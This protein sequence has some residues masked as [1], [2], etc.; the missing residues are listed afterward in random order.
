MNSDQI[1]TPYWLSDIEEDEKTKICEYMEKNKIRLIKS[2]LTNHS[3]DSVI[4]LPSINNSLSYEDEG[5][6]VIA[7]DISNWKKKLGRIH[8][9]TEIY[10]VTDIVSLHK[11]YKYD[12]K[13]WS[14]KGHYYLFPYKDYIGTFIID[15]INIGENPLL[16]VDYEYKYTYEKKIKEQFYKKRSYEYNIILKKIKE[17]DRQKSLKRLKLEYDNFKNELKQEDVL[18]I[19]MRRREIIS[20]QTAIKESEIITSDSVLKKESEEL[21]KIRDDIE[22]SRQKANEEFKKQSEELR[23]IRDDIEISRQKA[24]EEF[25]K[26]SEELRKIRDDIERSRKST[27]DRLDSARLW[28]IKA[29]QDLYKEVSIPGLKGS[30]LH[31]PM[32]TKRDIIEDFKKKIDSSGIIGIPTEI[33]DVAI[34]RRKKDN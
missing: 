23:K 24:N 26:Q 5:D 18:N 10:G 25:K 30:M 28:A 4:R 33:I 7:V 15:D 19:K 32:I 13:L 6:F 2:D 3:C 29:A 11:K 9:R 8:N 21:R 14:V 1:E 12:A 20:G 22:I 16:L 34:I 31:I 17:E 27:E